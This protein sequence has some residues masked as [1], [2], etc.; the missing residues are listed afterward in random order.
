MFEVTI[1]DKT[2][3]VCF[4]YYTDESRD[5]RDVDGYGYPYMVRYT[6][7]NLFL[8]QGGE[9]TL[10][11]FADTGCSVTENFVKEEGRKHALA[12]LLYLPN[13]PKRKRIQ[14]NWVVVLIDLPDFG[15]KAVRSAFWSAYFGRQTND[16]VKNVRPPSNGNGWAQLAMERLDQMQNVP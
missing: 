5:P 8:M 14:V 13:N 9:K 7:A 11:A 10:V 6:R 2:Y 15:D 4:E 16:R 12:H 3:R 1:G